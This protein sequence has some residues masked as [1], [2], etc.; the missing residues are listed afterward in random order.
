MIYRGNKRCH[1]A[2]AAEHAR[3]TAHLLALP[4]DVVLQIA[5]RSD[6]AAVVRCAATCKLLRREI[7][8]PAFIHSVC[9]PP[10]DGVGVVPPRLVGFLGGSRAFS[11]AHPKTPAAKN[12]LAP[13][14]RRSAAGL[15]KE[16]EVVTT[17]G[18]LA[19]LERR[20]INLRRRSE[21]RSDL[22]V[23]DPMT[24]DRAVFPFP[25]D[26]RW[27]PF[28]GAV[29]TYVVVTA[30]DGAIGCPFVLLAADMTSLLDFGSSVRVQTVSPSSDA[31]GGQWGPRKL[32]SHRGTGR[33][34]AD[35]F[36]SAV[37][38]RGVVHWLMYSGDDSVFTY[39]V[40]TGAPGTV[41]L[42]CGLRRPA[43]TYLLE[44]KLGA[45]PDGRLTLL[46]A[47]E[48]SVSL[49]VRTAAGS[50]C[51]PV[52]ERHALVDTEAP[53]R[54]VLDPGGRHG[55]EIRGE[56][57]LMNFGDQRSGAEFLRVNVANGRSGGCDVLLVL[58]MET[59]EMR[60][61]RWNGGLLHE[62]DLASRLSAMKT[63]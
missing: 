5:A 61:V 18:G 22:C 26:I 32:V 51:W 49:W 58:D 20:E 55:F 17:R 6:V 48:M 28:I 33:C 52:W 47:N 7:L 57:K 2:N 39:D 23:Y 60:K 62:V 45:T 13:F 10:P 56:V 14:V 19:V 63:F 43:D 9:R 35:T 21:R 16:Y 24:G 12:H 27:N 40:V 59:R 38:L 46:V 53:I 31:G 36:N 11:L 42:P 41:G 37:V 8:S 15:L 54:S 1:H 3:A 34:L 44:A 30:A 50:C 25:P 4:A 29:Y